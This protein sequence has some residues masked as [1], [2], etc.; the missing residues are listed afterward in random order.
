MPEPTHG[1][2]QTPAVISED[3]DWINLTPEPGHYTFGYY[4]RC[5]WDRETLYHLALRIPQ[6]TRLPAPG[7][8]ADVGYVRP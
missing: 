7:E 4:D 8:P 6:Q 1:G 2:R 3:F 5:A